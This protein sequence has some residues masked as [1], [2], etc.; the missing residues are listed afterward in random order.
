[1]EEPSIL[2]YPFINF[3]GD[4]MTIKSEKDV[5][6]NIESLIIPGHLNLKLTSNL[7]KFAIINGP[8]QVI[9]LNALVVF[10]NDGTRIDMKE[11]LK[12][13]PI[14]KE[15]WNSFL[16]K[17]IN[18]DKQGNHDLIFNELCKDFDCE[19][20]NSYQSFTLQHPNTNVYI[21][22]LNPRCDPQRNYKHSKS[23]VSS[24]TD[25][26]D[27]LCIQMFNSMIQHKT[28]LPWEQGGPE[29]FV[30][31][32][33]QYSNVLIPDKNKRFDDVEDKKLEAMEMST[34]INIFIYLLFSLF[35]LLLV[36]ILIYFLKKCEGMRR[37]NFFKC[38]NGFDYINV[39][40]FYSIN[41]LVMQKFPEF[42]QFLLQ[43][44]A[45]QDL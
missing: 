26:K 44:F 3:E 43:F 23:L 42:C 1:M 37:N 24:K 19:C 18:K 6:F 16:Y 22:L 29:W 27:L 2:L 36:Y 13:Y 5:N 31:N 32:H 33:K 17:K 34:N 8:A 10:W 15:S 28:L 40:V 7:D 35:I 38:L 14:Y 45:F 39:F 21:D 11:I 25:D 30:C 12:V 20:F 41:I 9:K 4:P